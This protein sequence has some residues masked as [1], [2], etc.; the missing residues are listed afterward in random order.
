MSDYSAITLTRRKYLCQVTSGAISTMPAITH[1]AFGSG[2]VDA[3]GNPLTPSNAQA[4]LNNEIARF[5]IDCVEY[6]ADTSARYKVTIGSSELVSEKISEAALVDD[7]GD[8]HAIKNMHV[9]QKDEGVS[10]VFTFDD[11]F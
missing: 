11:E 5:P 1:I 8:T 3:S 9:K 7:N 4:A 2:G 6:P 10:F